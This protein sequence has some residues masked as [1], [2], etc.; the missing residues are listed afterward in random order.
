M[1]MNRRHFIMSTA[2]VTGS[3]SNATKQVGEPNHAG[4][5]GGKSVWWR[6]TAP[7]AGTLCLIAEQ[8]A[9]PAASTVLVKQQPAR[10]D[11]RSENEERRQAGLRQSANQD[12]DQ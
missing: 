5:A 9:G 4:N 3:N 12:L 6:W 1:T 2:V 7:A 10:R 8:I 11:R